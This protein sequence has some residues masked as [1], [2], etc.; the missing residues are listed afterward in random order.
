MLRYLD[1]SKENL[2]VLKGFLFGLLTFA[3][4]CIGGKNIFQGIGCVLSTKGMRRKRKMQTRMRKNVMN[5]KEIQKW[6]P[7]T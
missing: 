4:E 2:D 7:Y 1:F 5:P 6:H 3:I